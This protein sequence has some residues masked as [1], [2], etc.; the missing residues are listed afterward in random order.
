M[1]SCHGRNSHRHKS[2]FSGK[3]YVATLQDQQFSASIPLICSNSVA[4][5]FYIFFIIFFVALHYNNLFI[6]TEVGRTLL[7]NYVRKKGQMTHQTPLFTVTSTEPETER[8]G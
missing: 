5:C 2:A 8:L 1:C 4:F 6:L 7:A 3:I